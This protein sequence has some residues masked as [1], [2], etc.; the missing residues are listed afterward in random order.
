[1]F[2][3][4]SYIIF[5]VLYLAF[6]FFMFNL[7]NKKKISINVIQKR[8]LFLFIGI[9]YA[10]NILEKIITKSPTEKHVNM[11]IPLG[12][13]S[14][15]I[16]TLCIIVAFLPN[17]WSKWFDYFIGLM[18]LPMILASLYNSVGYVFNQGDFSY[19]CLIYDG[20]AHGLIGLY[21]FYL[22]KNQF[23]SYTKKALTI[24]IISILL[25]PIIMLILN[26]IFNTSFFGLNLNGKHNIYGLVLTDNSLLSALLYMLGLSALLSL[27][28]FVTLTM[29]RSNNK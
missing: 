2:G 14:P 5:L 23:I 22:I 25:V 6:L 28:V 17:R 19:T 4:L 11:C 27:N 15:F 12:N 8:L 16:F 7:I 3:K 21:G 1:M 9:C 24:T 20:L 10:L 18:W 29:Q 13:Y 26:L